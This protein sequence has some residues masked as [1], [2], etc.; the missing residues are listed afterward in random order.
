[1]SRQPLHIVFTMTCEA[2]SSSRVP[3]GPKAWEQSAR[4]IEGF[5]NHLLAAGY[6]PTL[7]VDPWSAE[8]HS[9]LLEELAERGV[10]LGVYVHPPALSNGMYKR[11]LG[12]YGAEEQHAMFEVSVER[13]RSALEVAPRSFRAGNYSAND[14][15]FRL[16]F[17]HGFRQGSV[18]HP[19]RH[20][21]QEGAEWSGA[22]TDAHYV[23]PQDRLRAGTMPFL[24]VP[25]TTDPD[26]LHRRGMPFDLTIEGGVFE[27]WHRPLA[28]ARL[29]R[30][31]ERGVAFRTLCITT[32]NRFAYHDKDSKESGTLGKLVAYLDGLAGE[33]E[34]VP[35][36]LADAHERYLRLP[37][38]P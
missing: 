31:E 28:E 8:E 27:Q 29:G 12:Q 17:E 16:A 30:M 5:S 19:G 3:Y 25:V 36:T 23:D 32:L 22:E 1:M 15:T 2:V 13:V 21:P 37:Q 24:E 10:D 7:F 11:N 38:R 9:P 33:Y 35:A 6:P 26:R 18:S 4:A 20:L 34:L 14:D